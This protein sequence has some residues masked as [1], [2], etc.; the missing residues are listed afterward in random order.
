M[1]LIRNDELDCVGPEIVDD[2][3]LSVYT[4]YYTV[5]FTEAEF[6]GVMGNKNLKSFIPCHSKS[7]LLPLEQK[8]FET[9]L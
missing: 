5:A 9:G 8:W 2:M 1:Q 4:M 3:S 6:L 7:P